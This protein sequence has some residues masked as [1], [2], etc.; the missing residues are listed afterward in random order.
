M[1]I[2]QSVVMGHRRNNNTVRPADRR[3]KSASPARRPSAGNAKAAASPRISANRE[4]P[5][6]GTS[7]MQG[8]WP[9]RN[10]TQD[11]P[12]EENATVAAPPLPALHATVGAPRRGAAIAVHRIKDNVL[13]ERR[14]RIRRCAPRREGFDLQSGRIIDCFSENTDQ[15]RERTCTD[16]SKTGMPASLN[17]RP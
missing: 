1:P 10:A 15:K 3:G 2:L 16:R 7:V 5:L 17:P 14:Q 9:H 11:R 8:P 6:N 4:A 12:P 13:P